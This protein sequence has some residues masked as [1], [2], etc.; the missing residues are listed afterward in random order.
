MKQTVKF[1][2]KLFKGPK[3]LFF[4]LLKQGV[5]AKAIVKSSDCYSLFSQLAYNEK[6][7]YDMKSEEVSH[8]ERKSKT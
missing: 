5:L 1:L 4:L 2:H 3:G 8:G 6:Y 7:Q